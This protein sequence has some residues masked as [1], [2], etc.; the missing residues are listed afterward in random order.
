MSKWVKIADVRVL[1]Q[2]RRQLLPTYLT[3][4]FGMEPLIMKRKMPAL[5]VLLCTLILADSIRGA[6]PE[7]ITLQKDDHVA[8]IGGGLADRL[9]HDG[10]LETLIQKAHPQLNLVIRNLAF[11]GDQ[12]NPWKVDKSTSIVLKPVVARD[13]W[14]SRVKADVILA[15]Y[16]FNESFAGPMQDLTNSSRI[17]IPS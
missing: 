9:Q 4:I 17:S 11:S 12:V 1:P 8:I 6:E 7:K 10:W 14:L 2:F 3:I 13:E 15:F 5:F 16:G